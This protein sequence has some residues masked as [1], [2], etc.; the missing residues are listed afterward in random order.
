VGD[1]GSVNFNLKYAP[2]SLSGSGSWTAKSTKY[3]SG[4][5]FSGIPEWIIRNGVNDAAQDTNTD[6]V[7]FGNESAYNGN[8]AVAFTVQEF[9]VPEGIDVYKAWYVTSASDGGDD[10]HA[11]T[12][13]APLATVQKALKEIADT[14]AADV[15]WPGKGDLDTAD[16]AAI[17][18]LNTVT[19]GSQID[20]DNSGSKYP[21]ILLTDGSLSPGGTLQATTAI[22]SGNNLLKLQNGAR[23]TL[24]GGLDL[25]GVGTGSTTRVRGVYM[26]GSA[27]AFTMNGGVISGNSTINSYGGGVYVNDGTFTMN[28]GKISGNFSVEGGGVFVVGGTFTMNDGEISGNFTSNGKGGGVAVSID[29]TFTMNGGEISGNSS[30]I[31]DQATGGGGVYVNG[32]FTMNNGVISGNSAAYRGGGVYVATTRTFTMNGGVISGNS[33]AYE[34]GGVYLS[35]VAKFNFVK[36]GGT[37]Y[38]N[39]ATPASYNNI[40][41]TR[42][43]N[44]IYAAGFRSRDKTVG[45]QDNLTYYYDGTTWTGTGW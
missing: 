3:F 40:A 38:G 42:S 24:A 15:S 23:V 22:G 6:F 32:T 20:I 2:F 30:P 13:D 35:S 17:V 29:A 8:G 19:V 12:K 45:P 36:T 43:G 10:A 11:G 9:M 28:N 39:D 14:Y 31:F 37:I 25:A 16:Y 21:P 44:A 26:D 18:I 41:A 27:T 5:P 4:S 33:A 1:T 34:G 7:K